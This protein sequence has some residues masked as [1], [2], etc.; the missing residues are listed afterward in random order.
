M[1]KQ[2]CPKCWCETDEM[3]CGCGRDGVAARLV[4]LATQFAMGLD[5]DTIVALSA[6]FDSHDVG[7]DTAWPDDPDTL[8]DH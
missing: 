7:G 1:S 2:I 3:G 8:C 5:D 6:L 4:V